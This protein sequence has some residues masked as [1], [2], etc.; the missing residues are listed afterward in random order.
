MKRSSI[1]K[2]LFLVLA[3]SAL[4]LGCELI[5]DFDRT[6]I[7][8]EEA[9]GA[10]AVD[11]APSETGTPVEAGAGDAEAGTDADAGPDDSGSATDAADDADGA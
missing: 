5:V 4:A 8:V 6:R 11:A 10:A 2:G 1:N 3:T 7:P 9:D